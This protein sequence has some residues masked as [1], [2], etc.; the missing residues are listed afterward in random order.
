M[1]RESR[2]ASPGSAGRLP[3]AQG[4][5]WRRT[6]CLYAADCWLGSLDVI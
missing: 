4:A 5:C 1:E 2:S 6:V 3:A